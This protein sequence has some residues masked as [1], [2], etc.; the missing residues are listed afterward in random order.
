MVET[1]KEKPVVR[2]VGMPVYSLGCD[3]VSIQQFKKV[4]ER[5]PGVCKNIF[6]PNERKNASTKELASIFAAKEA[7]L[8]AVGLPAGHWRAVEIVHASV[9][10]KGG[11]TVVHKVIFHDP[12]LQNY[13]SNLSISTDEYHAIAM[14]L[15]V[16]YN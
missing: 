11:H 7:V 16:C 9:K 4:L 1:T 5:T 6:L 8:K 15:C 13:I 14:V 12:E 3:I 10:R 2:G